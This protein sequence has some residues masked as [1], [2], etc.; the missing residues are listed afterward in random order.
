MP[1]DGGHHE[2]RRWEGAVVDFGLTDEQEMLR[3]TARDFVARV[4]P[5]TKAKEWDEQEIFPPELLQGLADMGW[6]SMP[7]P[8]Q[9][10]GDGGGP[11]ELLL[12]AEELGRASFDVAMCFIGVLIPA[13]TVFRWATPDQKQWVRDNV[14]TGRQ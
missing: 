7:F 5:A 14:M 10:G 13:L 1:A 9:D 11:M 3:K 8:E 2:S 6:F 4:C 12:V